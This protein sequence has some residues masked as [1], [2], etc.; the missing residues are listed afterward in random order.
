M[1][2]APNIDGPVPEIGVL[3][4]GAAISH[5]QL[6]TLVQFVFLQNP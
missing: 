6:V 3:G 5:V 1:I 2:E 4:V